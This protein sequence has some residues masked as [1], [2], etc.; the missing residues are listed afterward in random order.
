MRRAWHCHRHSLESAAP[1]AASG[2]EGPQ[3]ARAP[4]DRG[5]HT[6]RRRSRHAGKA[7]NRLSLFRQNTAQQLRAQRHSSEHGHPTNLHLPHRA[8]EPESGLRARPSPSASRSQHRSPLPRQGQ[9][10]GW[11]CP[12][13]VCGG[14][15]PFL[16]AEWPE[17]LGPCT[18]RGQTSP[19]SRVNTAGRC[20]AARCQGRLCGQGRPLL[21]WTLW[22]QEGRPG[23]SVPDAHLSRP[24]K[25]R[26][27]LPCPG[28]C[29][30]CTSGSWTCSCDARPEAHL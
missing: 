6:P 13:R 22:W 18:C 30:C 11:W 10:F 29:S 14:A 27:Q 17:G 8:E 24:R 5:V 12:S 25:E 15:V 28:L 3:S 4:E 23:R 21:S 1:G 2:L 26:P 9:D 16:K 7:R 20:A 19:Q